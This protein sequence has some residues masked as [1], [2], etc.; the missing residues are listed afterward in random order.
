MRESLLRH[1][2]AQKPLDELAEGRQRPVAIELEHDGNKAVEQKDKLE[3][4]LFT[5]KEKI[6]IAKQLKQQ[7]EQAGFLP[8]QASGATGQITLSHRAFP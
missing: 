3:Q 2:H 6:N 8:V 1:R 7:N 4:Q 5:I